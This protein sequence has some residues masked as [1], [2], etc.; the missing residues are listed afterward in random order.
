MERKEYDRRQ[1]AACDYVRRML[2][3]IAIQ[4]VQAQDSIGSDTCADLLADI[5]NDAE[6]A[7]R[8]NDAITAD[9]TSEFPE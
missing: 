2:Q 9:D 1:T 4:A 3:S 8:M 6:R 5:L 7:Q